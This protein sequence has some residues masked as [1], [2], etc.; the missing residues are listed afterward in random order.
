MTEKVITLTWSDYGSCRPVSVNRGWIISARE[1]DVYLNGAAAS[2]KGCRVSMM[3][4]WDF[5]TI[6][7]YEEVVRLWRDGPDA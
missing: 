1:G 3:G 2:Q 5:D 6:E 7:T 4:G